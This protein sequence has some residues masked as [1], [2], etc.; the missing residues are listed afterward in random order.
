M[1][2]ARG[3]L[4]EIP[5][6]MGT[7]PAQTPL[8]PRRHHAYPWSRCPVQVKE[9]NPSYAMGD[10]A[11][12]LGAMWKALSDEEKAKY[13]EMAKKDKERYEKEKAEYEGN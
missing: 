12:E 7:W 11:K 3:A 13:E 8:S 5:P 9:K 6:N 1:G 2:G 4:A 10:I